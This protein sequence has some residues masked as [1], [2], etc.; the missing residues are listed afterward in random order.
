MF[1]ILISAFNATLAF[2]FRSIVVK[3]LIMFA[4]FFVV[5]AFVPV[6]QNAGLLPSATALS[7]AFG[8]L[9]SSVWYYLHVF[10]VDTG[11]PMVIAAWASRFVIRRIPFLN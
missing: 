10:A 7:T 9:P 3:F 11:A 4:L 2:V 6:L 8:S 5:S 1:A